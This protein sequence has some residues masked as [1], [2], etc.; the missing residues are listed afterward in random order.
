MVTLIAKAITVMI[1]MIT[2]I[3]TIITITEK[4]KTIA[5]MATTQPLKR[6]SKRKQ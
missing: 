4:K 3:R 2:K 6:L 1:N 5:I